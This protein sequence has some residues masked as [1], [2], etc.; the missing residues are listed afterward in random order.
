MLASTMTFEHLKSPPSR[1]KST[2]AKRMIHVAML[3]LYA[4]VLRGLLVRHV[5][6]NAAFEAFIQKR[7]SMS[8]LD[9]ERCVFKLRVMCSA[10]G[11]LHR[12][13]TRIARSKVSAADEK[14]LQDPGRLHSKPDRQ[15]LVK[16]TIT[17]AAVVAKTTSVHTVVSEERPTL[18]DTIEVVDCD[19]DDDVLMCDRPLPFEDSDEELQKW[20]S[21]GRHVG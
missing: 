18:V 7:C 19:A 15:E 17:S 5:H 1:Y 6:F 4:P 21:R 12:H 9:C 13:A 8:Q 2:E 11:Y 3:V 14:I 20:L 16:E 10:I